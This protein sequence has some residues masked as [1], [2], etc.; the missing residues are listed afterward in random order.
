MV[1]VAAEFVLAVFEDVFVGLESF[2]VAEAAFGGLESVETVCKGGDD[3][4]FDHVRL[5][6][7]L[8]ASVVGTCA[9][10]TAQTSPNVKKVFTFTITCRPCFRLYCRPFDFIAGKQVECF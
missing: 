10:R 2:V 1:F 8:T 3:D 9:K 6:K 5:R 4:G 7:I